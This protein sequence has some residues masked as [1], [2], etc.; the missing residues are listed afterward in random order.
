MKMGCE[1]DENEEN[2]AKTEDRGLENGRRME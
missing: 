2:E 1:G